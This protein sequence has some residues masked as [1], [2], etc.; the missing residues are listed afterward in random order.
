MTFLTFFKLNMGEWSRRNEGGGH[1]ICKFWRKM[2]MFCPGKTHFGKQWDKHFISNVQGA[3]TPVTLSSLTAHHTI[4][5]GSIWQYI[6]LPHAWPGRSDICLAADERHH[7]VTILWKGT[8]LIQSHLSSDK[9]I[10]F[11]PRI[12]SKLHPSG[13]LT[14]TC[15]LMQFLHLHLC[16]ETAEGKQPAPWASL[17]RISV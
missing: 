7:I 13:K 14:D 6:S 15:W 1:S 3:Y 10:S 5:C 17:C 12:P 16:W 9:V 2:S 11:I 4:I 8:W